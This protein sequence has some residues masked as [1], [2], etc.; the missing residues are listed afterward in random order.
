MLKLKFGNALL[1]DYASP[2][3]NNK[4]TLVNVIAGDI[5]IA[6]APST[7]MLGAYIEHIPDRA[8]SMVIALQFTVNNKT[9]VG[10]EAAAEK[11]VKS[12]PGVI[13][14]PSVPVLIEAEG[15]LE[16]SARAEGYEPKTIIR[17]KLI[18]GIP[19]TA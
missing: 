4:H 12:R 13:L 11:M 6:S 10:I 18:I 2:G 16:V 15:Q 17:K 19:P 14:V 8:G 3:A 7:I 9:V 5:Y 1:C